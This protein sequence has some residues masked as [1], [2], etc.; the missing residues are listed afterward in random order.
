MKRAPVVVMIVALV[1]A[2]G[3]SGLTVRPVAATPNP[4]FVPGELVIQYWDG[5][6][7]TQRDAARAK[8][9]AT[10]KRT[11]HVAAEGRGHLEVAR[12]PAN[13][14]VEAAIATLKNDPGVAFA[15][16]NYTYSR[17]VVSAVPTDRGYTNGS[18][19]GMYGDDKP[20][21]VGPAGTTNPYGSQ[22]EKAWA[23]GKTGRQSVY[24]GVIDEGIRF[25]HGDLAANVWTNLGEIP[26]DGIDNDGDGYIDDVHGWDFYHHDATVY[27]VGEDNHGTHVAG[28]I[29]ARGSNTDWD[30][31][32]NCGGVVGV[33][34]NVTL[35]SAK[36]LGPDGGSLDDAVQAIDYFTMLKK[37][38][39]LNIVALNN[40]WTGGGDSQALHDAI[41]RAAKAGI[42]FVAA[43]GNEGSNNDG[44]RS[45]PSGYST[46]QGTSTESAA[47]Y[48]SVIAVAAIDSNGALA[49]FSNY[50]RTTVDLGAPGVGIWSTTASPSDWLNPYAQMSG[51]SMATPH[52]TGAL[53]LYASVYMASGPTS[54]IQAR[55][56]RTALLNTV[57]KT[58]SLNGR[59]VTNGRLNIDG[60]VKYAPR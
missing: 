49:S 14:N 40:S 51:T 8:V 7:D 29:G 55:Q 50:G 39:G 42:L 2:A 26:D 59:T 20:T 28:T 41:I 53:A 16:P 4:A 47:S 15:E 22:A 21:P 25:D 58:S 9:G 38:K 1:F 11:L 18:L 43:A 10:P 24:V 13:A 34:W 44:V 31:Q 36:F 35:I 32:C 6:T 23:A 19:W 46:L 27:D 12:L 60:L 3:L 37:T 33:N 5:S 54:A 30:G 45:Y 17:P 56:M 52:V 48:E 57:I